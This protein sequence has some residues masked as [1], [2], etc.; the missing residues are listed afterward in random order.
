MLALSSGRYPSG[1]SEVAMT[2]Q[3]ASTFGVHVGG[4]W[5]NAG[6]ELRIVGLVENP[7][8]LLDNFALIAPGQVS[9]LTA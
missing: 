8:N 4:H 9:S 6:R 7:Q 3:L 5:S 2:A 1:A